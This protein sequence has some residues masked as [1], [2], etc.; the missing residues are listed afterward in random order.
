MSGLIYRDIITQIRYS[1]LSKIIPDILFFLMFLVL[2]GKYRFSPLS[3]ILLYLPTQTSIIP[4]TLKEAD[5]SYKGRMLSMTFPFSKREL[6]LS[7]YLSCCLYQLYGIGVMILFLTPY[8]QDLQSCSLSG[9]L[10]RRPSDHF[11][12]DADQCDGLFCWKHEYFHDLLYYFCCAGSS[13]LRSVSFSGYRSPGS[14]RPSLSSSVGDR[15]GD[16]GRHRDPFIQRLYEC[17]CQKLPLTL[18]S[19]L[20]IPSSSPRHCCS[21]SIARQPLAGRIAQNTAALL[22]FRL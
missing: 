20:F 4:I 15:S 11:I 19:S 5:S 17:L 7:R 13:R 10:C 18:V 9:D 3:M 12:Y 2:L 16:R 22:F 21:L 1:F 6:V 8:I 14:A